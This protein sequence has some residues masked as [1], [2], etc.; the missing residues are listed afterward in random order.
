M[1]FLYS[2][3]QG[4]SEDTARYFRISGPAATTITTISANG[5]VTW[6]NAATN[7]TCTFQIASNLA[8]GTNWADYVQEPVSNHV[9]TVRLF[10]L[11][12]P[13]GMALIPAGSFTMGDTFGE[14]AAAELP[15]H[16]VYVSAFYMDRYEVTH[17]LWETV[18]TWAVTNGYSFDNP[19]A[20][21][22]VNHPVQSINWYDMVKWCNARSEKENRTPAYYTD[23]GLTTIYKSGKVDPYVKWDAGYRLPTEA[24][25]EKA[26]R[27]GA[28]GQRFP[29]ADT[30]S[31]AHNRANFFSYWETTVPFYDYDL[32]TT[33]GYHPT[34]HVGSEPYTAPVGSFAPNGYGLYD[35]AGNMWEWCWDWYRG[36]YYSSSPGTDPHG[37]A[38]GANRVGRGG[39]NDDYAGYCRTASR[40]FAFPPEGM[41]VLWGFRA[42]LP[43]G[44]P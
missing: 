9:M 21:K 2:A 8:G 44:Q 7:V 6:T 14:G 35:M 5:L 27:G 29:W 37:P 34:Y 31:I 19:G 25:W 3:H 42:L 36:N 40:Y 24:E 39:G 20:G 18:R 13:S 16:K 10:D 17:A 23:A 33:N 4:R 15:T 32:S 30:N 43:A 41:N 11:N 22:A 12:P 38:T 26:G 28:N 1:T